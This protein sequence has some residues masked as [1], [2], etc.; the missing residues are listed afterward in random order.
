M[1]TGEPTRILECYISG[2]S[3][4]N[5]S[6]ADVSACVCVCVCVLAAGVS[7]GLTA[8]SLFIT[9]VLSAG[10]KHLLAFQYTSVLM[11]PHA[12]GG[13]TLDCTLMYL[14]PLCFADCVASL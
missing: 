12:E 5:V 6:A 14:S 10:M 8:L 7:A 4:G 2:F 3:T 1:C 11:K 13:L 9:L